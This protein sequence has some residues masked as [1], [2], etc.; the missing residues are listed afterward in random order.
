MS[1]PWIV[2]ADQSKARIFTVDDPQGA[3]QEVD[4]LDHPEARD[5]SQTLTSDRPGRSFDSGGQGRHAMGT[6]VEPKEQEAIR[7]AKQIADHL[8][9]ACHE[10][11]CNRLVLVA[12]P[13]FLG[14][15]REQLASVNEIAI[16]EIQK[17]LGQYSPHEIR[18]HLPAR[19]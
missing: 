5:R 14:M 11:G 17:N 19:L 6:A 16:T 10:K 8:R 18:T 12:G 15:L 3:L 1:R 13:P 7:F 2:V 9:T 4:H